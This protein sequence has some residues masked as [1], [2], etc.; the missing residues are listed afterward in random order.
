MSRVNV[1]SER[2]LSKRKLV[3][4][5]FTYAGVVD[6]I[7]YN[8]YGA[9]VTGV[10][11]PLNGTSCSYVFENDCGCCGDDG[12][13]NYNCNACY[14]YKNYGYIGGY[15]SGSFSSNPA[16]GY[17]D[18]NKKGFKSFAVLDT[19]DGQ[20]GSGTVGYTNNCNACDSSSDIIQ[21]ITT[22]GYM[23]SATFAGIKEADGG[24]WT[25]GYG[26][27]YGLGD[28]TTTVRVSPVQI[29]SNTWT[30]ISGGNG[31]FSAIRSDGTLWS[32]G[33]N[34]Y[35]LLGDSTS[36]SRTSMVQVAGGGTWK[37]VHCGPLHTAA[38]KTDG[39]L[40]CWGYNYYG[41]CGNSQ[42]YNTIYSPV[43]VTGGGTWKTVKT[44]YLQ[45]LA[46]KTDG[47]MWGFGY[48][49]YY[50]LG[51][52]SYT[53]YVS[54]P[55]LVAGGYTDWVDVC[56]GNYYY[57]SWGVRA[58]GTAWTWGNYPFG[59][60]SGVRYSPAQIGSATNYASASLMYPYQYQQIGSNYGPHFIT[61]AGNV[62]T[63]TG[64]SSTSTTVYG[65]GSA[66]QLI[67]HS[68]YPYN[69]HLIK[70]VP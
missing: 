47:T 28:G 26:S 24:L 6:A 52:A 57:W 20:M 56:M 55:T 14:F 42:L 46:I 34:Y 30:M 22:H 25:W 68:D 7:G 9:Y 32:W 35:G 53:G 51:Q 13:P 37:Y 60:S 39:T 18:S 5:T 54:S 1:I 44:G 61:T 40:W 49:G 4:Q 67:G 50:A 64:Y 17:T 12:Y 66:T 15:P 19:G 41:E 2:L 38:I 29:G 27:S 69:A 16:Q 36:T 58:N 33:W 31:R 11:V 10:G 62:V 21:Y 48:N 23:G 43:Q 63:F 3:G 45:T 65:G 70:Y 59:V 8:G